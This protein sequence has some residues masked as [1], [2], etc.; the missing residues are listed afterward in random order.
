LKNSQINTYLKQKPAFDSFQAYKEYKTK[1]WTVS[2]YDHPEE[3]LLKSTCTC[4]RFLKSYVC[5]HLVAAAII[6]HHYKPSKKATAADLTING[7][8]KRSRSVGRPSKCGPA[9]SKK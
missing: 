7:K 8:Y 2:F 6:K 4:P 1:M 5:K 3:W 9:L